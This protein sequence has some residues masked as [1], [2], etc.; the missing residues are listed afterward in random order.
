MKKL[1]SILLVLLLS[2]ASM[3]AVKVINRQEEKRL[4]LQK[5]TNRKTGFQDIEIDNLHGDIQRRITIIF[6]LMDNEIK[7]NE[8]GAGIFYSRKDVDVQVTS[9][10]RMF[11]DEKFVGEKPAGG[12]RE[13]A[14]RFIR[15]IS[16]IQGNISSSKKVLSVPLGLGISV[17]GI[18]EKFLFRTIAHLFAN[19]EGNKLT[20]VIFQ[21]DRV[22]AVGRE[23]I[24]ERRLLINPNPEDK[25]RS[26]ETDSY[27][28]GSDFAFAL[29]NIN[30]NPAAV[31]KFDYNGDI[32]VDYFEARADSGGFPKKPMYTERLVWEDFATNGEHAPMPYSKQLRIINGYKKYLRRTKE[33]LT[34]AIR[35]YDLKRRD[36]ISKVLNF[37]SSTP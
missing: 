1:F 35:D 14:P 8:K 7:A 30:K 12:L 24:A 19:P 23:F 9:E 34:R 33:S 15:G 4:E 28:G 37:L 26:M 31:K 22:N 18:K 11:T 20:G 36:R 10:I 29:G 13:D 25:V 5:R 17:P 6:A 3:S 21:F 16:D 27:I 2:S 32:L